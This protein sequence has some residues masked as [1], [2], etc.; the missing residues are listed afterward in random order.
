[1]LKKIMSQLEVMHFQE[2]F[3]KAFC[4]KL[5]CAKL[6]LVAHISVSVLDGAVAVMMIK[7]PSN[8]TF[9]NFSK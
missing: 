8:N 3:D 7:L 4:C 9:L 1:M 5:A 6:Q 2:Y